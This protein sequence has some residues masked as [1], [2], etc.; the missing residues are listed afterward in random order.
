MVHMRSRLVCGLGPRVFSISDLRLF[1]GFP[2]MFSERQFRADRYPKV[3]GGGFRFDNLIVDPYP[4]IR[5]DSSPRQYH[6]IC[7][8]ES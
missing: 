3:H 1:H 6:H 8:R 2:E 4:Y 7:L 5:F